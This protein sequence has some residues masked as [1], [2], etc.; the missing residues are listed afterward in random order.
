MRISLGQTGAIVLFGSVLAGMAAQEPA[1]TWDA[2]NP[3]LPLPASPLGIDSKLTDLKIAPT[4]QR[5]RL[6]RW[7]FYDKRLSADGTIACA[8]C[9]VPAQAFSELTSVSSGIRGQKGGRKAPSFINQ[10][11]TLFPHFFWDGRAGS[12]E[13]Q[14]LGPVANPIE[15]GNT[16]EAMVGT[17][18][19]VGAYGKY[20]KEAFGTDQITKERV[21]IAIADYERTRMSGNSP[22][23]RWR[24]NRNASAVSAEVKKGHELF[25]GKAGCNQCHL[26]Q[27]FTDSTFH[28]LGIGW[29]PKSRRFADQ[30]RS[31]VTRAQTDQGSFKT[32]TLRDVGLHPPYMHDGSLKTLREV[33]RHYSVGGTRNPNLDPKMQALNLTEAEI[34]ALVKFMEALEGEGYQDKPPAAFP[35]IRPRS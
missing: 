5:V 28:N 33:V 26:G 24:Q 14:A 8:T 10:A 9:H 25:F 12:L 35:G 27:N 13:E 31:L 6:G 1:A 29:N 3:V 15:M 7:L 30:G 34:T 16:H 32:P 23:D 17:L 11:W 2:A 18:S 22:W 21:A 19:K 4:P 20:F